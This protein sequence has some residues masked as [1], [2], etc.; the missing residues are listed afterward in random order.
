[1]PG[2]EKG[3]NHALQTQLGVSHNEASST[4]V[5]L[6]WTGLEA[7]AGPYVFTNFDGPFTPATA[8]G[9]GTNANGINNKGAAVG[10]TILD[11]GTFHN[12]IRNPNGTFTKIL[13]TDTAAIAFGINNSNT[14]VGMNGQ[15][16]AIQV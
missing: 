9:S 15:M 1:M 4:L 10:F 14:V 8:A 12:F 16:Q 6:A 2:E 13:Q 11:D 7:H 5:A 3:A